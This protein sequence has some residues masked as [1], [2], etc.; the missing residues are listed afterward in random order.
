M[1]V[2]TPFRDGGFFGVLNIARYNEAVI[3]GDGDVALT[4]GI[5]CLAITAV[6]LTVPHRTKPGQN[7]ER[8]SYA[9]LTPGNKQTIKLNRIL[10]LPS[11]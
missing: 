6:G 3:S 5:K 9:I 2:L 10:Q 8:A 1:C 4:G 11:S 7:P